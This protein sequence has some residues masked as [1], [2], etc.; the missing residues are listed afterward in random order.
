MAVATIDLKTKKVSYSRAG[1]T[2]LLRYVAE[3]QSYQQITGKGIM[4]GV[5]SSEVFKTRLEKVEFSLNRNDMLFLYTDGY[6]EA[7]NSRG[8]QFGEER[9]GECLEV[10]SKEDS[11]TI[12]EK[13]DDS[14][15]TFTHNQG[16]FD[17]MCGILFKFLG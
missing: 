7:S 11:K 10:F 14:V 4:L 5:A 13:I 1:H 15:M 9:L 2:C 12:L 17:D 8:E 6:L 16:S 3:T